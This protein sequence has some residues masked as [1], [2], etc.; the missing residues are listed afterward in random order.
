MHPSIF[1]RILLWVL[2]VYITGIGIYF[3]FFHSFS[4]KTND[5]SFKA[6]LTQ[7]T[8]E[9]TVSSYVKTIGSKPSVEFAVT[10][11]NGQ[12]AGGTVLMYINSLA[13][14]KGQKLKVEGRLEPPRDAMLPGSF[15]WSRYLAQNDIFALFYAD[16]IE[17]IK[18]TAFYHKAVVNLRAKFVSFFT[19]N[20]SHSQS[21][22]VNGI[23]LGYKQGGDNKLYENLR[24]SG[25]MHLLV[26]SGSNVAFVIMIVY[27][28]ASLFGFS[29]A[30]KL[31]LGFGAAGFYV[32][33]A[34]AEAP[35]LRAFIM[36]LAAAGGLALGR[37]SGA[38]QGVI[39]AALIM[40]IINPAA[41]LGLDFILSFIAVMAVILVSDTY[42]K[43]L[44]KMKPA[45]KV[46][47]TWFMLTTASQL[48]LFPVLVNNFHEV[49][50]VAP[51]SNFFL[52]PLASVIMFLGLL[53]IAVSSLL[54]QFFVAIVYFPLDIASKLFVWFVNF[55]ASFGFSS[56]ALKQLPFAFYGIWYPLCFMLLFAANKVML[57]AVYKPLLIVAGLSLLLIVFAPRN[58]RAF[59][60]G[61]YRRSYAI[62]KTYG[63]KLYFYNITV[64]AQNIKNTVLWLG[65]KQIDA[66]ILTSFNKEHLHSLAELN[67]HIKIKTVYVPKSYYDFELIEF[68]ENNLLNAVPVADG[69]LLEDKGLKLYFDQKEF[70]GHSGFDKI[71]VKAGIGPLEIA[72]EG[73]NAALL[74][75]GV[76][77]KELS[78]TVKTVTMYYNNKKIYGQ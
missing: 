26:A 74:Y 24:R 44:V 19:D 17:L 67:R 18:E 72:G 4:P 70:S 14:L 20:F 13:A 42:G 25:A 46:P 56:V 33:I 59:L 23:T 16:K 27:F 57:K 21:V 31:V 66:V 41:L 34:G 73:A 71:G 40:L 29:K 53:Y 55:F 39:I 48:A 6:P 60:F 50:V 63:G 65:F 1:K 38:V 37:V 10:A 28:V 43:H 58:G 32:I 78:E 76:K 62:V 64:N 30:V 45:F 11:V 35:L 77:E 9:G 3:N 8:V 22:M 52:I 5:I 68:F 49:S 51:L 61:D 54:P 75:K 36:A 47:L 15:V 2:V 69:K 7:C 12:P